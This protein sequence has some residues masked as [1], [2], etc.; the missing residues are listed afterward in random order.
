MR[1][2]PPPPIFE[3]TVGKYSADEMHV[4]QD[5]RFRERVR[6]AWAVPFYRDRWK[7]A[8]LEPGDIRGLADIDRIPTFTSED[9]K[10]AIAMAPPFGNHH[11]LG[12]DDFGRMPLK[13]QT[14]GGTTG[15]PRVTL[16]DPIAWEVQAIQTARAFYS[17]G[18]RPGDIIQIPYTNSLANAAWC[19][20]KGA[21][22]WLGCVPVTSGSGVVTPTERQIE[23]ARA[24]GTNAWF[25][26][27]EYA[28]RI[29]EV[30]ASMNF[31]LR[32]LPTKFL[33]SYLG[34][35]VE[36]HLR[37][38]LEEA[39][40]APVYDNWGTH[41]IGLVS[42]ECPVKEG[43]HI[44]EDTV[45]L[46]A[47]DV[48]AGTPVPIGSKGSMVV[49]S[50]HRSVPPIIRY[51]LRDVLELSAWSVCACGLCT[52]KVGTFLGR[53]DEMVKLRGT[54]VFPMACQNAVVA[55]RR[56]TGE[57]ICVAYYVGEGLSRREEMTVQVERTNSEIDAKVMAEDLRRALHKDLSVRVDV[58]I[59]DAGSLSQLT[60]TGREGKARRLLDKRK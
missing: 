23:Y 40:G 41:E 52:R 45:Y 36:G 28:A 43:K 29:A 1:D 53:A 48:D 32:T 9:L 30:A 22:D 47:V 6:E 35:D 33:H 8:G 49:T 7:D 38:R 50:L 18:A 26:R 46:Q 60:R 31:D 25:V 11:P 21:H 27:G 37:R 19:A 57:F 15:L 42:W 51:D 5:G 2:Y 56:S 3:R 58:E 10:V 12:R 59:V 55:D 39:W 44:S 4:L 24:W 54:N 16:F 13:I 17:H 34:T 20:Y 14:S